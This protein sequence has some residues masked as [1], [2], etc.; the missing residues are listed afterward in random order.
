MDRDL[1]D[2][3][4]R[5]VVDRR[6]APGQRLPSERELAE[7]LG[8]SRPTVRRAVATLVEHGAVEARGR[9]GLYL[10]GT[11]PA[12]LFA[13]RLQLEPWAAERAATLADPAARGRIADLVARARDAVEDAAG[14]AAVDAALHDALVDAADNAVLRGVHLGLRRRV[15]WS[16]QATGTSADLR[17]QTLVALETIGAAVAAH[18]GVAARSAMERHLR[19]VLAAEGG[20]PA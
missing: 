7:H 5:L 15:A 1:V 4:R 9:S 16:R 11:D 13:V 20:R 18:D 3:L 14:F 12:E 8:V 2:E 10:A 19:E 6:Y 17:R